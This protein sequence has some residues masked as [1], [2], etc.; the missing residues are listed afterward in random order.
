MQERT[1]RQGIQLCYPFEERRLVE[2]KFGWKWPVFVQPKLDGERMRAICSGT[3]IPPI[4]LS[5]TEHFIKSIPHVH[6]ELAMLD[7]WGELDGEMYCH[8]YSF[9]QISSIVSR[10]VNLHEDF[11]R[12]SYYVFDIVDQNVPQITRLANLNTFFNAHK[13][14]SIKLVPTEICYTMDE[15][16]TSYHKFIR[17]RYEGIIIRHP[18]ATYSRKRSRFVMKFKPKKTDIYQILAIM[19]GK[20][21]HVGQVG[22]FLCTGNDGT[23][24]KVSAGE[25]SHKDRKLIWDNHL[26][27]T[28][29]SLLISYQN[30]TTRGIPRFGLAKRIIPLPV[31]DE[32]K[33]YQSIL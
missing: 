1:K 15:I 25:L 12:I 27:F 20:G 2:N 33:S 6:Q 3:A 30:I 9:E 26:D 28:G 13:F 7:F 4:L 18:F 22:A 5:S 29:Q 16:M 8:G 21:E 19:E 10:T 32:H 14:A 11:H 23:S 31:V 17:M 24:F